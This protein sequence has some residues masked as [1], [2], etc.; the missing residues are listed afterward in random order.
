M[1][2]NEISRQRGQPI[3]LPVRPPIFYGHVAALYVA[4]FAQ[5]PSERGRAQIGTGRTGVEIP[6]HRHGGLLRWDMG[7]PPA[8]K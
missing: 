3:V 8:Q 2:A 7:L 4:G 5:T 1:R 6:D